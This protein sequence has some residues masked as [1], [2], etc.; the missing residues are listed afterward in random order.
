MTTHSLLEE[1]HTLGVRIS[2]DG[3]TLLISAPRGVITPDLRE[4]ISAQKPE[5]I[6]RLRSSSPGRDEEEID[7]EGA[8]CFSCLDRGRQTQA[9]WAD[10]ENDLAYCA[11]H[12]P[13]EQDKTLTRDEIVQRESSAL[14]GW[15]VEVLAPGEQ[16]RAVQQQ[17]AVC[18]AVWHLNEQGQMCKAREKVAKRE[19]CGGTVWYQTPTGPICAKCYTPRSINTRRG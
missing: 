17:V 12:M 5:L 8:L 11:E 1:L 2:T 18:R 16:R 19:E 6:T 9:V 14:P 15:D 13:Q 4:R 10:K 3:V 7:L